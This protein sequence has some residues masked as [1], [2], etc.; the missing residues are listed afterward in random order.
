MRFPILL[1]AGLVCI[2][3]GVTGSEWSRRHPREKAAP[4]VVPPAPALSA[5]ELSAHEPQP[6]APAD[7]E[8]LRT[9]NTELAA[10]GKDAQLPAGLGVVGAQAVLTGQLFGRS[11]L[12]H[13]NAFFL[14]VEEGKKGT[15][16]TLLRVTAT[17]PPRALAV[18]RPNVGTLAA[19]GSRLYWSEGGAI[20][21]TDAT[22]GGA[23]KGLIHFPNARLTSL[24]VSGDVLVAS[25]VPKA[26]DPFSSDAVGAVV[27]V[28]LTGGKVK[29]LARGLARPVDARTDG[30]R[31]V[32]ISGYPADLWGMDLTGSEPQ[33]LSTRADGPVLLSEGSVTFRHPVV[34]SPELA[35]IPVGGGQSV[36]LA[37]GEIDRVTQQG[38]DV[39]Y[40]VGP[41]V[42]RV[43]G[44]N[45]TVV[46]RLPDQVLELGATDDALYVVTRQAAGGHLLLRLPRTTPEGSR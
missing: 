6:D 28:A 26:L 30:T 3:L 22:S 9:S 44:A 15:T 34:G 39:W 2:A 16:Q 23:A 20:F 7:D 11:A 36:P 4:V 17:E 21:S 10:L 42:S 8:G 25:L 27:S 35:R 40:S 12:A 46:A 41:V 32:W 37:K 24:G 33:L 5:E 43:D 14:V 13:G 29:V 18:H 31:A 45:Q 1:V 38:S 19:G